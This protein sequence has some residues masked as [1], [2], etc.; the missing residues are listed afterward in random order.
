[1]QLQGI[2]AM[3][4]KL[5]G[6]D[7]TPL[8][9]WGARQMDTPHQ[10]MKVMAAQLQDPAQRVPLSGR[11]ARQ[12]DTRLGIPA[13]AAQQ[14]PLGG[15][16]ASL[17]RRQHLY[18]W[19]LGGS[20]PPPRLLMPMSPPHLG[21]ALVSLRPPGYDKPSLHTRGIK[22]SRQPRPPLQARRGGPFPSRPSRQPCLGGSLKCRRTGLW[23]MMRSGQPGQ[24]RYVCNMRICDDH[25]RCQCHAIEY[26][27]CISADSE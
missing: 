25:E 26:R 10:G 19:N 14:A 27:S 24:Q 5:L 9:R 1:M 3:A 20:E 17:G 16:P 2:P 18:V 13:M 23:W 4:A 11:G 15:W 7:P 8:S 21:A 12:L 6:L 22:L